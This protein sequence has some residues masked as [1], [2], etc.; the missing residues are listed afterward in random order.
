[1]MA[2]LDWEQG[3][4]KTRL[5]TT[6]K[7]AS[8]DPRRLMRSNL[9][10]GGEIVDLPYQRRRQKPRPLILICDVSDS[11]ERYTRMLLHFVRSIAS[12]PD[13][14]EAFLFATRLI[15]ITGHLAHKDIDEAVTDVARAVSDWDGGTRIG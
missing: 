8:L 12:G 2:W 9:R 15:R 10:Y 4:R 14:V 11:M 3:M 13:Q 6:E 1:M 7:S 5:W